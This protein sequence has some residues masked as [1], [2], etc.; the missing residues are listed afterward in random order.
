MKLQKP[1]VTTR[2]LGSVWLVTV[3]SAC[4]LGAPVPS[5]AE[6]RPKAVS[7]FGVGAAHVAG[8]YSVRHGDETFLAAGANRVHEL[9]GR[10]L[11]LFLT[12]DYRAKY[13]QAWPDGIHS[14]A[15]LADSAPF[16]EVF[17]GPFDTY[18]LSTYSFSM[19]TGDP[20]RT[21]P[22]PALLDAEAGELD[23]LVTLLSTRY[24][25]TGKTFVLQTWEGDWALFGNTDPST[26]APA[27]RVARMAEWLNRRH[28]AVAQARARVNADGVTVVDAVEVNR[29]LDV[30]QAPRVVSDVLPDVCTDVV[31]YS[32]WE[33]LDLA[34]VDSGARLAELSSRLKRAFQTIRRWGP[35]GA[36]V[37]LGEVGFAE[38]AE[39]QTAALVEETLKLSTELGAA[40]TVYW[41]VFDNEC[42]DAEHCRG[43]WVLRP[44]G[45][46]SGAGQALAARWH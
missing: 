39:P 33:A 42:A 8:A 35:P 40:G 7:N 30:G 24:A 29:V 5:A 41:Q 4:G 22:V 3:A 38:N 31:S 23:E 18:V 34:D 11:K 44:D 26:V 45:S 9:G 20:W 46:L 17:S 21:G 14:L 28:D 6:C 16:R 27:D 19:G 43:F 25:G 2:V 36:A 13:P 1:V 37:M 32:A 10:T 15:Q 12:P